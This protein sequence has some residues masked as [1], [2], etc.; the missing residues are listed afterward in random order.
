M[1]ISI[2]A[3]LVFGIFTKVSATPFAYDLCEFPVNLEIFIEMFSLLPFRLNRLRW[4]C[5]FS[6]DLDWRSQKRWDKVSFLPRLRP[7][8]WC[9]G[10]TKYPY[11]R[12]RS[13]LLVQPW[14]LVR[15][16][17]FNLI[18]GT[19]TCFTPSGGGPDPNEC[20]VIADALR[21]D[22][23]NI[24]KCDWQYLPTST[25]FSSLILR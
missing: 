20:H 8:S 14:F 7:A 12:L 13:T 1:K 11:K 2:L 25:F 24:G 16:L 3:T 5:N 18:S 4:S 15:F 19:T 22:S 6:L 23:Q 17:K 21:F 9:G 10:T